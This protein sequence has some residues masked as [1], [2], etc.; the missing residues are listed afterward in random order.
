MKTQQL[1]I[2]LTVINLAILVAGQAPFHATAAPGV[3]PV[4]RASALEIVD[5]QGRVRASIKIHPAG[6]REP[7]PDGKIYPETV[8]LRLIN[9][10]GHPSVKVASSVQGAGLALLG[11]TDSTQVILKAEGAE[12]SLKLA[13]KSGNERLIKP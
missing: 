10:D 11:D 6:P 4:L 3:V 7:I 1:A 8:V 13:N 2:V 9:P 5:N 12:S